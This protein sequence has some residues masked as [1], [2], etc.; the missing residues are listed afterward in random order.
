MRPGYSRHLLLLTSLVLGA[1]VGSMTSMPPFASAQGIT[2]GTIT[3]SVVDPSGSAIPNA[4][5]TITSNS[6]GTTRR[7]TSGAAGDFSISAVPIG[8]YTLTISASGFSTATVN[9][10]KVNA[11]ATSGL[12]AISLSLSA[13][14]TQVEVNGSAAALLE[15]SDSQ[16]TTTLDS[17]A[18]QGIPLNNG[19]DT[20]TEIIPGVVSTHGANFSNTNGDNFSVNGQSGRANNFELDGQANN[21]NSVA[22]PQVFFG[23]QDAIQE[24]QVITNNYSAQYGRN[25]GAVVNYI[26]KSGTNSYHGSAFEFYQG[27]MLA[28]LTNTEKNPLFG[29]CAPGQSASSGCTTP[30]VPRLVENRYGGT[31]GGPVMKD[32]L[33]LFGSTYW[34]RFFTGVVPSQS[35][36]LMTPTPAGITA[37]QTAFP[38]NAAVAGLGVLSPYSLATGNPQPIG[39]VTVETITGPNGTA[40]QIPFS[41]VTRSIATPFTDQEDLGR[42]DWSPTSKDHFFVRYFYQNQLNEGVSGGD[43]A[44]G[45]FVSVPAATHSIGADW[46]RAFSS[47]WVDQLR[48]SFQQSKVFFEGGAFPNCL[49]TNLSACPT[50]VSFIGSNLDESLGVN[51]AFP[52]GR[53]VKVTQLQDNATWNHG[54]HTLI[55]GG[56]FDLQNSPNVF[57]ANYNGNYLYSTFSNY[58]SDSGALDIV[59]GN[60]VIPFTES[61]AAA[62]IQ[63]DWKVT[64]TFTAHIGMRWEYFGAAVNKLHDET[65]ARESNPATAFFSTALPLSERT[66]PSVNQIYTNFEPRVGFAWNPT[67]DKSLVVSGG[68]AINAN[69]AFYNPFLNAAQNSPVTLAAQLTCAQNCQPGGGNFTGTG[70]RAQNLPAIPLGGDPRFDNQENFPASFRTPYV[71]TYTL[72]LQHQ[73]GRNVVGEIRYVGAK[74]SR[75][76]QAINA[77]PF[78]LPVATAFPGIVNPSGLCSDSTQPGFGRPSCNAANLAQVTNTGWANYQGLQLNLTT[79]NYHGL[80]GTLSYTYSRSISNATDIFQSD[81][82]N[83]GGGVSNPYAQNPLNTSAGESGVDG[84]SY[85]NVVGAGFTYKFPNFA[86]SHLLGAFV[87]GFN[88]GGLYRFTNGQAF[89][90]VQPLTLDGTTG[91]T[92]FCDGVFNSSFGGND[93]CRLVLSNPAAPLNTVAYYNPF[94]GPVVGGAPTKGT[95]VYVNYNSDSATVDPVTGAITAYNPGTPVDPHASHWIVNNQAYALAV[96]NPYPGSGRN[97]LRGQNF[98][99]FDV[100]V[101]KTIRI[102]ERVSTQLSMSTYNVLNQMYRNPPNPSLSNYTTTG[103]NAFLSNAEQLSGSASG[104][105]AGNR[106]VIIGGK[107]VF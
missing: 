102:T 2:T 83:I 86:Q 76:F 104:N 67:F 69:P 38:G 15:T 12:K 17:Q 6:Q 42:L 95:P 57:L 43:V 55:F 13:A 24:L 101:Y 22:G 9:D 30:V 21:D 62:Y 52:Q 66:A 73:V 35:L 63:D 58:I 77:N 103:F 26:T 47:H 10:L 3:G 29:F 59:N 74:T 64:P 19:F 100:N 27:D 93:T 51:A 98:S 68:Y 32:K 44:A 106:F 46:T 39:P 92:S 89:N 34:D 71:Q 91:D 72:A 14:H 96:G 7:T 5:I 81:A 79:Q 18:V 61:D 49:S 94:T 16:V 80:T 23:S 33:F 99:D 41:G 11:G 97:I 1:T 107:I 78:L 70:V 36:P 82:P 56:E 105:T 37:L 54:N 85:P 88:L 8:Q 31:L 65:V 90:V 60:P 25:A 48:Y 45:D 53:T 40:A 84:N 75:N 20:A 87:N 50:S 28:S 4:Q